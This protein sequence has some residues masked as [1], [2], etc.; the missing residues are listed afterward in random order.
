MNL[1]RLEWMLGVVL[2]IAA[3]VACLVPGHDLPG[4]F[5]LN[6]KAS[7]MAGHGALAL[8]FTGLVPRRNWWKIF[9]Y[10]M[11]FGAVIEMAQHYMHLGRNG[12]ARDLLA[13]VIGVSLGLLVG[14]L[15]VSR[16]PEL[17]A[18]MFGRREAAR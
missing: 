16:W 15:G 1:V 9:L 3:T 7:H 2:M 10:L 14:L 4:M 5:E 18:W 12:D 17:V 6:D 8:Y 13:N 11:L